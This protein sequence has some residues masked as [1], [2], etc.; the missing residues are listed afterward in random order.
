MVN[1]RAAHVCTGSQ[2]LVSVGVAVILVKYY[3]LCKNILITHKETLT[4]FMPY[5]Q[6]IYIYIHIYIYIYNIWCRRLRL[7]WVYISHQSL[8]FVFDFTVSNV[9]LSLITSENY[10]SL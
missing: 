8:S 10:Y 6:Y 3:K 7:L 9:F 1:V 2:G 4:A 5:I